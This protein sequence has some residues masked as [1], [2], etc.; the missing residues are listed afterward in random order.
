[1]RRRLAVA[2]VTILSVQS[3]FAG[4]TIT[5]TRIIYP[6][7]QKSVTVQLNNP[8]DQPAMIQAWLDDGDPNS[9]PEADKIPFL[10]TP[11]LALIEG[12]KGQML[13]LM[14]K[15]FEHLPQDRESL[16]WFNILDL[17]ATHESDQNLNKL[18][19]SIRSRI[20]LFYRPT[21]LK[22]SQEKAFNSI[23]AQYEK[24]TQSLQIKNPSPYY[25]NFFSMVLNHEKE[26]FKYQEKLM[27]APFS[28]ESLKLNVNFKPENMY[29]GLINDYG[30]PQFYN[31]Q[32]EH[33]EQ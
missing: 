7:N 13:R 1:M 2:F 20:K 11:P 5:G 15:N 30:A 6:S 25:L 18:N 27:I 22:F 10:L 4:V 29:V 19:I 3:I 14:S 8:L 33:L 28:Q 24:K 16:Y 32:I 26:N 31:V 12:K 21:Q 17:P 9:I 23:Q